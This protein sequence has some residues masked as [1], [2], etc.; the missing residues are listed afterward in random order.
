MGVRNMM[1]ARLS[2][3][4]DGLRSPAVRWVLLPSL[5]FA[6]L[7]HRFRWKAAVRWNRGKVA[8]LGFM[9]VLQAEGAALICYLGFPVALFVEILQKSH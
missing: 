9:G 1:S 6:E 4:T 5:S 8:S 3:V 2:D 7:F